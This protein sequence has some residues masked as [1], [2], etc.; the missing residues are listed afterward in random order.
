MQYFVCSDTH[1]FHLEFL[2]GLYSSGFDINNDEHKLIICGDICDGGIFF[3]EHLLFLFDLYQKNKVVLLHGNHDYI[4]IGFLK[5]LYSYDHYV[6][7]GLDLT[8]ASLL[9][10][11]FSFE[12]FKRSFSNK[13]DSDIFSIWQRIVSKKIKK[14]Y[15]FLLNFIS[16]FKD[17]FET[18]H[19]IFTHGSIDYLCK[20][21]HYPTI[22]GNKCSGWLALHFIN[23][24]Y[25]RMFINR[26]GKTLVVGHLNADLMRFTLESI[27][28]SSF[29]NQ[30][31]IYYNEFLNVYFID[32]L[33][34]YSK[35]V[36]FLV[37]ND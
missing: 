19:Y 14:M 17:Y 34:S 28:S 6:N 33:T 8:I 30:N 35:R 7:D 15:P 21:W 25:Y 24:D 26:T 12:V 23:P 10:F 3:K 29:S 2:S 18:D 5:N 1:G 13:S 22:V 32:S 9:D 27:V 20:D 36:N 37:L 16:N 11:K 4:L 31:S